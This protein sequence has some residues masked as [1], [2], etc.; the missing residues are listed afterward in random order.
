MRLDRDRCQDYL[1]HA[2]HGVLGTVHVE[3][4]VD[5][6]PVCFALVGDSVG[7]PA[8]NVKPKTSPELQ[9]TRNLDG[10]ARAVLLCDHWDPADWARLWWVRA[11]LERVAMDDAGR[12][13]LELRLSQKYPQ[14]RDR[15]FSALLTFRITDLVGWSGEPTCGE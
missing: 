4:G 1:I 3:R 2:D 7:V 6:V 12:D 15:P 8:D 9:R 14:Y 11:S 10:D 13:Q 5:A